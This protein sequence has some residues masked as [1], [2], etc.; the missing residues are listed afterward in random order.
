MGL[1]ISSLSHE[2][3]VSSRDLVSQSDLFLTTGES[4]TLWLEIR[5]LIANG[6]TGILVDQPVSWEFGSYNSVP[7]INSG[8]GPHWG[9]APETRMLRMHSVCRC[10]SQR[11]GNR[12]KGTPEENGM[13]KDVEK[14]NWQT[15]FVNIFISLGQTNRSGIA[16]TWGREMCD[17]V[18]NCQTVSFSLLG[19]FSC[20][21][22]STW[23]FWVLW[24]LTNIWRC[25]F[26]KI[27]VML[28]GWMAMFHRAFKLT[29][30]D[31]NDVNPF[32]ISHCV[33]PFAKYLFELLAHF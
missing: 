23:E 24:I 16:I 29:F 5:F 13:G 8:L 18:R 22:S 15:Q 33:S 26:L 3:P 4:L 20:T 10:R 27:L 14:G 2:T 9:P 32:V 6:H 31:E 17:S 25:Q 11:D 1:C 12:K 30:P 19:E 7:L 28:S 21:A